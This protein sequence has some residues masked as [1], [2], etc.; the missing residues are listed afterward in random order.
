MGAM[1]EF[2]VPL[3]NCNTTL[4]E[5]IA[6][7]VNYTSQGYLGRTVDIKPNNI[8]VL[9]GGVDSDKTMIE[10][11]DLSSIEGAHRANRLYLRPNDIVYIEPRRKFDSS[12]FKDAS[13]IVS[14]VSGVIS[15]ITSIIVV[16]A[17]QNTP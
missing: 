1:G 17:I 4:M 8:R 3:E 11:V 5:A 2:V 12:V 14:A 10:I 16:I 6:L 15:V 7:G 9:R 13:S